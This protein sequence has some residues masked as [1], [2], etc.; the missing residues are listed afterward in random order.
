MKVNIGNSSAVGYSWHNEPFLLIVISVSEGTSAEIVFATRNW[1]DLGSLAR[2]NVW[3][4]ST[5][6]LS[7]AS[8]KFSAHGNNAGGSL[9]RAVEFKWSDANSG[10]QNSGSF[11]QML[12]PSVPFTRLDG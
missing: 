11:G 2:G 10:R 8:L 4:Y 6:I 9:E 1:T 12:F 7:D 5:A 3:R